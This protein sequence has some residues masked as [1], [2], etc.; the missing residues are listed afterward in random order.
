MCDHCGCEQ[1]TKE[2]EIQKH[3]LSANE[4]LAAKNRAHFREKGLRV[5]NLISSPGAGKT[6][7]LEATIDALRDEIPLAVIEGDPETERD[8]ARIR[9]KGVPVVQVTTGGACHLDARMVHRAFHQLEGNSFRL[10]FIENVGNLLCPAAFDL[11]E[12]LRVVMVSVPEGSDKPAKYP[13]AFLKAQVFLI[14]KTDLLPYFDFDLEEAKRL[15]LALNPNLR[16]I[17]LSAKT[18]EGMDEWLALLRDLA[19]S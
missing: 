13:A 4:E 6:T 1:R 11:G 16:I 12:D 7:L 8:A 15:A 18:G 17:A 10:L 19:S 9:A 3:I 5:L 2:V 14:T